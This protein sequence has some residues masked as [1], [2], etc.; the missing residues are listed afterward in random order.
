MSLSE[1][2]EAFGVTTVFLKEVRE[3]FLELWGYGVTSD[4]RVGFIDQLVM[5]SFVEGNDGVAEVEPDVANGVHLPF[6]SN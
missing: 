5:E 2:N 4:L 1:R 6:I 3:L